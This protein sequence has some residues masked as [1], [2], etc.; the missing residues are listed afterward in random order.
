MVPDEAVSIKWDEFLLVIYIAYIVSREYAG[1]RT[2]WFG[3][4]F[5]NL[6]YMFGNYYCILLITVQCEELFSVIDL[7]LYPTNVI[8]FNH[9]LL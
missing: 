3:I 9:I 4:W 5:M 7:N 2:V 6:Y 8:F 1:L